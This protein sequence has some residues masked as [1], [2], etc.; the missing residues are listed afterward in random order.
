MMYGFNAINKD[1]GDSHG[2]WWNS[3][4]WAESRHMAN[5]FLYEVGKKFSGKIEE[6]SNKIIKEYK[7]IAKNLNIAREKGLDKKRKIE[8][9]KETQ[10][11]EKNCVRE[12]ESL[13]KL[14]N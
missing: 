2:H 7:E 4:V 11:I 3:T 1:N 6:E 9:L 13:E 12:L 5:S 14:L 10:K 8:I